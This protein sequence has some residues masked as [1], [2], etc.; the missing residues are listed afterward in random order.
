MSRTD[1]APA[2]WTARPWAVFVEEDAATQR[3]MVRLLQ[4]A[5]HQNDLLGAGTDAPAPASGAE[6]RRAVGAL[7][8]QLQK[9]GIAGDAATMKTEAYVPAPLLITDLPDAVRLPLALAV[10]RPAHARETVVDVGA[11]LEVALQLASSELAKRA[12]V[13]CEFDSQLRVHASAEQLCLIVLN[14]LFMAASRL[15]EGTRDTNGIRVAGWRTAE[16]RTVVEVSDTGRSIPAAQLASLFERANGDDAARDGRLDLPSSQR[17]V[18]ARGG[19]ITVN[20]TVCGT[21]YRVELPT[22][23]R[24]R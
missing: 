21:S 22:A 16:G 5:D 12:R 9:A 13:T 14:L 17:A 2:H 11:V 6:N 18:N 15:N 24:R 7:L 23:S 20:S 10:V 3:R 8:A 1:P 4:D 19:A